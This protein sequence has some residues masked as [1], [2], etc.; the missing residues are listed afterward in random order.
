MTAGTGRGL[1][2]QRPSI[3]IVIATFCAGGILAQLSFLAKTGIVE[4]MILSDLIFTLMFY[5]GPSAILAYL[6]YQRT[7][8]RVLPIILLLCS[9]LL[10][11]PW[12]FIALFV[13]VSPV[14]DAQGGMA[15]AMY[16]LVQWFVVVLATFAFFLLRNRQPAG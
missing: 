11:G 3:R 9:I 8:S 10:N 15:I 7:K 1:W 5:N 2:M 16:G 14:V 13:R 4:K 12:I 6:G